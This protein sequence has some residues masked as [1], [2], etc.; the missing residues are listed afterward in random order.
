MEDAAGL[1]ILLLPAAISYVLKKKRGNLISQTF[2]HQNHEQF[3]YLDREKRYVCEMIF[4][5][6]FM[7]LNFF[8]CSQTSSNI[9]YFKF[10]LKVP[11]LCTVSTDN[12]YFYLLINWSSVQALW[13]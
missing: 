6:F 2:F 1:K 7:L 4:H 5:S 11:V 10:W 3:R 8:N 9:L 12:G 13:L